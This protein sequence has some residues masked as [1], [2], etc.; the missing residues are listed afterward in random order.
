MES[1]QQKILVL[2]FFVVTASLLVAQDVKVMTHQFYFDTNVH[3]RLT[4]GSQINFTAQDDGW[5]NGRI[6]SVKVMGY[7]D[8]RGDVKSNIE[9]SRKR[10]KF[11]A[12]NLVTLGVVDHDFKIEVVGNGELPCSGEEEL[13]NSRDRR[14][15]VVMTYEVINEVEGVEAPERALTRFA[16]ACIAGSL[17]RNDARIGG[18]INIEEYVPTINPMNKA[19][20]K[21]FSV[22]AP[23]RPAPTNRIAATGKSATIEVFAERTIVWLTARF[24]A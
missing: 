23:N 15:D 19:K 22:P 20:D 24:T 6:K 7:A 12:T 16:K 1:I 13:E 3:S 11:I 2:F 14:V 18:A 8:C 5:M 4:R 21:S 10:A 9:L 17:S